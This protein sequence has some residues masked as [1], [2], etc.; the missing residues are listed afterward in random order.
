M[1]ET[2]DSV[3]VAKSVISFGIAIA[4]LRRG[5]FGVRVIAFRFGI[6]GTLGVIEIGPDAQ[7]S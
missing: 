7:L 6:D 4:A 1:S 3:V 2:P 5:T